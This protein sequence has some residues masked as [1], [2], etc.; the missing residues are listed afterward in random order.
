VI[1]V[2]VLTIGNEVLLGLVQDTNSNYLCRAVRGLGGRVRHIAI[3]RDEADEIAAAVRASIQRGADLVFTCGGLGPTDDDLTLKGVASAIH[4]DLE[5]NQEAKEMVQ[6][7]YQ[8]LTSRGYV[9]DAEMSES[10]LKMARLPAGAK[11][12]ENPVGAAPAVIVESDG[13]R[14]VSL[15]GVPGELKT[16]VEGPLRDL[17]RRIFGRGSYR[18][19]ELVVNCGDESQ[20]APVLSKVS[21]NHPEVYIK[22]RA[23]HFGEN[24]QFHILISASAE[25]DSE[26]DRAIKQTSADLVRELERHHIQTPT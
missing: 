6:R 16:I 24:L 5:V 22:P 1:N 11:P 7:R 21:T 13:H 25:N 14:I 2:E 19:R 18:E 12:I 9:S 20:L 8:E 4:S 10:R 15:P 3:V 23:S 26:A 17:L